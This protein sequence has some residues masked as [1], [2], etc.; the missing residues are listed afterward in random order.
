MGSMILLSKIE[1][2]QLHKVIHTLFAAENKKKR[3]QQQEDEL[4][5]S[6]F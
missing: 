5:S 4:T 2:K 1:P 3:S 6:V